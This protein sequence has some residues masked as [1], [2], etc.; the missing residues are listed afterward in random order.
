MTN[1]IL[2]KFRDDF[3][4][5]MHQRED[6]SFRRFGLEVSAGWLPLVYELF[7]CLE[8]LQQGS[9]E[10]VRISQV[11]Q[12]FGSLR[13]YLGVGKKIDDDLDLLES[14]FERLSIKTCD[15][16]GAV[17]SLKSDEGYF[18]TRCPNHRNTVDGE[19]LRKAAW[20]AES[21]FLGYN[22]QGINTNGIVHVKALKSSLGEGF[23]V[24]KLLM[25][26]DSLTDLKSG[27][28]SQLKSEDYIDRPIQQLADTIA[29][30]RADRKILIGHTD[31]SI[32]GDIIMGR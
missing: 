26:P 1:Q 10:A 9:G 3:P 24:L 6:N 7:A 8:D 17:G 18:C 11:K 12:K 31:G 15:I 27:L 20:E 21:R 13:V 4:L 30:L 2:Q 32:A 29:S 28:I 19:T 14:L 16:C 25:F 23:G 5:L 22:R